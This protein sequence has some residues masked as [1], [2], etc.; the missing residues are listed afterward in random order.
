MTKL[1]SGLG[2]DFGAV[3]LIISKEGS[4]PYVLEVNTAPALVSTR[5]KQAYTESIRSF[6][7]ERVPSYR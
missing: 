5:L 1:R 3:D 4:V 6:L 2:L 7:N